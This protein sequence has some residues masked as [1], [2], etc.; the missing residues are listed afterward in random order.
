MVSEH[1]EALASNSQASSMES[2]AI[3]SNLN[4]LLSNLSSLVTVKLDGSNFV[5]WK[6]QIQNLLRAT[7]LLSI[8]DGSKKCP[9]DTI[10]QS[11]G[12]EIPNPEAVKWKMIDAHLLSCITATLSP[13]IFTSVLHLHTS[14]Q[15]WQFLDKRFTSLSRSHIHQLKNKLSSISKKSDSMEVYLS[16]IKSIVDQL[17]V[18]SSF[19]EDEDIV[20]LT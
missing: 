17:R 13:A 4:I 6:N 14:A 2:S 16:K 12:I 20:L 19:V 11:A 18:A 1:Q 5:I 8:V 3:P 9:V 15:V 7:D 10:R